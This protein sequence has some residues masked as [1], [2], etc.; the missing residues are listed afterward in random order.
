MGQEYQSC[1]VTIKVHIARDRTVP[2][3]LLA[4]NYFLRKK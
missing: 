4:T 3:T 1:Y 2:E